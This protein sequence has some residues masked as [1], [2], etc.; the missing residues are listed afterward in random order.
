MSN[1]ID[2]TYINENDIEEDTDTEIENTEI[3]D[4]ESVH[5]EED[6]VCTFNIILK[7]K[8]KKNINNKK[9]DLLIEEDYIL[10]KSKN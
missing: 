8:T 1:P 3:S 2:N 5:S 7:S 10:P 9:K 4:C 6:T